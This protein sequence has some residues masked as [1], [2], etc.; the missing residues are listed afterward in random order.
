M[1]TPLYYIHA[2]MI[3]YDIYI[4]I[5][6]PWPPKPEEFLGSRE[7]H[8]VFGKNTVYSNSR[9]FH[10]SPPFKIL[11]SIAWSQIWSCLQM[12]RGLP[13]AIQKK[14]FAVGWNPRKP[15]KITGKFHRSVRVFM[16]FSW[17]QHGLGIHWVL[18]FIIQIESSAKS[19]RSR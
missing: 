11:Q 17:V 8:S 14:Q 18:W 10:W 1:R 9:C 4:Y 3:M 19:F 12:L 15:M 13:K 16:G 2:D 7:I 5:Y 6:I